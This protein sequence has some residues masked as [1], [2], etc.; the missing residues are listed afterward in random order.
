MRHIPTLK[1]VTNEVLAIGGAVGGAYTDLST[2][3]YFNIANSI[4]KG[5]Y[6]RLIL[7]RI[8]LKPVR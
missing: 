4:W 7:A 3:S 1:K 5:T 2:V 6:P 8:V